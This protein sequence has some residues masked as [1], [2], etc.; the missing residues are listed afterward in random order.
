MGKLTYDQMRNLADI[1]AADPGKV[2]L[3]N[4]KGHVLQQPVRRWTKGMPQTCS[5]VA[6]HSSTTKKK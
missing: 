5:T 4:K 3:K 2:V 1:G 6:I